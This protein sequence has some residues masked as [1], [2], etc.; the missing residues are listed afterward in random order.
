MLLHTEIISYSTYAPSL[1]ALMEWDVMGK[2]QSVSPG[3]TDFSSTFSYVV[4]L[5]VGVI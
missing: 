4:M 3:T 1:R 2:Y 5:G